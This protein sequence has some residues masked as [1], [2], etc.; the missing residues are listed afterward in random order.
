MPRRLAC[1]L[2]VA[3]LAVACVAAGPS[4]QAERIVDLTHTFDAT[5]IYWPTEDGFRL[6]VESEG[7]RPGGY[8]YRANSF[9]A[10]EHGGT[11]LDAPSH[12]SEHGLAAD[13]LPLERLLGP[14]V[15]VDVSGRCSRNPD[16]TV[17]VADLESFESLHGRIP[18]AAI[19]LL[20]TGSAERWPDRAAYLGTA[21]RGA[22]A[23]AKLR[24]PGLD[25]EAARWLVEQRG[26]D[27]VGIDTASIDPGRS[28]GFEAHRVLTARGVPIFENV[29]A[30]AQLPATGFRVV[31]LPMKIGGGS[32]GPLRII[33]L[34]GGGS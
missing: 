1:I 2:S 29:A 12:F 14:G 22:G 31:A 6:T 9:C 33:A 32:G 18:A 28:T 8:F 16:C 17:S 4:Q 24:F 23:V 25:A 21:E 34:V 3:A 7:A 20:R 30:L 11:H 27:A 13:A 10:A 5:T 15:V 26:I 19:V